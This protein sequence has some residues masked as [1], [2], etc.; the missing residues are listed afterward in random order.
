MYVARR[1]L[2]FCPVWIGLARF[3]RRRPPCR[4]F[5]SSVVH[6]MCGIVVYVGHADPD[7]MSESVRAAAIAVGHRGPDDRGILV[8][9]PSRG[10]AHQWSAHDQLSEIHPP[11]GDREGWANVIFSH[12]RL[13][14]IDRTEAGHQPMV[15]PDGRYAVMLNGEIYNYLELRRELEACGRPFR[16]RSDTEVLLQAYAEW[17]AA[18]LG[19]LNGMYAIAILDLHA[20]RLFLARDCFGMKPLYYARI[21]SG[22]VIASEIPALLGFRGVS[23]RVDP[24]SLF[25]YL[26]TGITGH[27]AATPFADI[28]A[29]PPAHSVTVGLDR[30]D[31]FRPLRYWRLEITPNERPLAFQGAASRLRE[32][33]L[34]SV[35]LHLRSDVPVGTLLSGGTDSSS[36]VM[37]MR[38]L[39]GPSLDLHTFSYIGGQGA[40]SEESWIDMVNGASQ[41]LPHKVHLEPRDWL[42]DI[43]RVVEAQGEPFG[44][45]AIYAQ[46]RLFGAARAAGVPVVLGGQGGDEVMGGYRHQWGPRLATMLREGSFITAGRFLRQTARRRDARG[47]PTWHTAARGIQLSLPPRFSPQFRS[48]KVQPWINAAW[49]REQRVEGRPPLRVSD[50]HVLRGALRHGMEVNLPILLR[51]E[52]RNS[53]AHSVEGRLP[54]LTRELAEFVLSLP[55]DYVIGNDGSTKRVFREAMRGIVPEAILNRTDKVGFAVP[56]HTWPAQIPRLTELLEAAGR[57]PALSRAGLG[58]LSAS[59]RVGGTLGMRQAFL[60]WRIVGVTMWAE[61]FAVR[62]E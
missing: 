51:Y 2:T 7:Q 9:R 28:R 8:F 27:S 30:L 54:F 50:H 45:I 39:A 4:P 36:I 57:I 62:F 5:L 42:V 11:M 41:A 22:W 56:V 58:P 37:A 35:S 59:V 18:C 16:S 34:E 20:G 15:S 3:R 46:Y 6:S 40:V 21:P 38:H 33:F 52:D 44:S 13:A 60:L 31:D 19:R 29:V 48:R 23:R 49:C 24:Q 14:I 12:R 43:D 55:E 32:L 61:R 47:A 26:D 25:E 17:G 10:Q 53:M 1:H